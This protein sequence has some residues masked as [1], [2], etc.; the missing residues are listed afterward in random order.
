MKVMMGQNYGVVS[1]EGK[2]IVPPVYT[3]I[4]IRHDRILAI[5][6]TGN[7]H[8]IDLEG[9]IRSEKNSD[10]MMIAYWEHDAP[11]IK[12]SR[13]G[14]Y[15]FIDYDGSVKIPFIYDDAQSFREGYAA[16]KMN[17]QW[18]F[19]NEIG[20]LRI[21]FEFVD[22]KSFSEGF[23]AIYK[24]GEGWNFINES[25]EQLLESSFEDVGSFTNGKAIVFYGTLQWTALATGEI[26]SASY[27]SGIHDDIWVVTDSNEM[28]LRHPDYYINIR[29]D[30]EFIDRL[31]F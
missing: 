18:G 3:Y 20:V 9:N 7:F 24:R 10:G 31:P 28:S 26:I 16:V 27:P 11:L 29:T 4:L 30:Y 25:N 17:G 13:N 5:T 22:V 23:A 21:P 12:A 2:L 1:R 6:K 15:G 8:C 19:I 14:K